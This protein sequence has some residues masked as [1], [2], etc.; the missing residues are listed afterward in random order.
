[1]ALHV[2]L[3]SFGMKYFLKRLGLSEGISVLGGVLYGLLPAGY[4]HAIS[5]H[6]TW[7]C[8]SAWFPWLLASAMNN[9]ERIHRPIIQA[10]VFL[11]MMLLADMR[12]TAYTVVFWS[13]FVFYQTSQSTSRRVGKFRRMGSVLFSLILAAGISA[14]FWI[15][16]MEY[17]NLSTRSLLTPQDAFYLSLP[18]VQITGLIVPGHPLSM[19]WVIYAGAGCLMFIPGGL[20]ALNKK[21]EL[22]FWYVVAIVSLLWA[23]GDT[24]PVNKW[25]VTLPGLDLLRVPARGMFFFVYSMLVTAMIVLD[26]LIKENPQKAVF[27]RLGTFFLVLFALLLQVFVVMGN[28][29]KN[30]LLIGHIAMWILAACLLLLYSYRRISGA[31]FLLV[32]GMVISADLLLADVNLINWINPAKALSAAQDEVK[33]LN[34]QGSDFRV[35]SPSYSIPQQTASFFK[36]ELADGIDPLQLMTYADTLKS[37]MSISDQ[38]YSVTLPSFKT[39]DPRTDNKGIQPDARV[40]GRLNVKYLVSAFPIDSPGWDVVARMETSFI[41]HN[42]MARA[43]AWM[44]PVQTSNKDEY[45]PITS[46]TRTPNY[47]QLEAEGPGRLVLSEINYPGWQ[48]RVDGQPSV[49]EPVDG[50]LRS[51]ILGTG[52]HQIEFRYLPETVFAG[53]G[54]SLLSLLLCILLYRVHSRHAK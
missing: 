42:T 18:I 16:L 36:I 39:G 31:A 27:L 43:W 40:F 45:V 30:G 1:M 3:G 6:F 5:G 51:V 52:N 14:I 28:P 48:V 13:V 29:Q 7:V 41:Y 44:E 35:F 10:S 46:V 38:G 53:A 8:A 9:E 4:S 26:W 50:I 12:F 54:I 34:T 23:L 49:I 20:V 32:T 33:Y 21:K 2:I 25:L 37:A 11:G 24:I 17:T 47:I 15:P 22:I 19:E